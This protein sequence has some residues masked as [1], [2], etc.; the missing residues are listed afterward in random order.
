MCLCVCEREK[1]GTGRE[2]DEGDR[3]RESSDHF[4]LDVWPPVG[5]ALGQTEE[6]R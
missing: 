1:G 4:G 6:Q 5:P 2:R 3:E